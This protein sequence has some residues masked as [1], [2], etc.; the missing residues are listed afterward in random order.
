MNYFDTGASSSS[1]ILSSSLIITSA[2]FARIGLGICYDV[3]FPEL[4]LIAARKGEP[5]FNITSF[6]LRTTHLH[7]SPLH[8][9]VSV[10]ALAPI[11]ATIS[12][13]RHYASETHHANL[14][15]GS[16]STETALLD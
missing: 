2:G 11:P 8:S 4:A 15:I 6:L 14:L 1:C 3:R 10:L 5:I 13:T 7:T 12:A 9:R 16:C